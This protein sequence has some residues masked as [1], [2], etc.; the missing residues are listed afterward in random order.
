MSA[1]EYYLQGRQGGVVLTSTSTA[2]ESAGPFRWLQVVNDAVVTSLVDGTL[3]DV[4]DLA[5]KTLPA[6]LG[7]GGNFSAVVITSGVVIGYYA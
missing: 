6:G 5:G 3:A 1:T 2:G 7:I 4:G